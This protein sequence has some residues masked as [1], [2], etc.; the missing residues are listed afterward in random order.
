MLGK[1]SIAGRFAL[2]G[3]ILCAL[4]LALAATGYWQIASLR[5]QVEEIPQLMDVRVAM[6]DWQG[7]TAA[8]A[9]RT[10]AILRSEDANLAGQLAAEM[11]AAT[12]RI[13]VL[14]KRIEALPLDEASKERFAAI[15]TARAAYIAAREDTLK[16]KRQSSEAAH[17]AFDARFAPALATYQKAVR[18]FIDGYAAEYKEE[19]AAAM[20][21]AQRGLAALAAGTLA[22]LLIAALLVWLMVRSVT[23][24]IAMAVKVAEALARGD[25]TQTVETSSK[26][27]TG[28]LMQ[29]LRSTLQQLGS[30]VGL[31]KE[32]SD[33][34]G[35]ASRE[36]AQGNADLSS[37][38][39]SRPQ[40]GGDG[41]LDGGADR[42]R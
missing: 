40:P 23:R 28:R 18:D 4:A 36:I 30:V 31:I 5:G 21:S 38:P 35:T 17:V 26:D 6:G 8:N 3:A 14:Q 32:L 9:A 7:E 12:A 13:S 10:V 20:R 24:P 1:L 34:V 39:R 37:A 19:H 16:I 11:K 27:E 22:F 25:L 42:A 15:G 41:V 29:A 2:A 33:T